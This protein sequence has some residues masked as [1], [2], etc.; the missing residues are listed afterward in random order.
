MITILRKSGVTYELLE[1]PGRDRIVGS[2]LIV[3]DSAAG[4]KLLLQ[5]IDVNY[6]SVPGEIEE[7]IR[8]SKREESYQVFEEDEHLRKILDELMDSRILT[9]KVRAAFSMDDDVIDFQ[10][11]PSRLKSRIYEPTIDELSLLIRKKYSIP[12]KIGEELQIDLG[13]F[14]GGLT[15]II[16]KKGSGKSNLSKMLVTRIAE[17]GGRCLVFDVNGEYEPIS[18]TRSFLVLKPGVNMLLSISSLGK[19]LFLVLMETLMGLPPSSTWEL[20]RILDSLEARNALTLRNLWNEVVTGRFNDLVKEAIVR[21]LTVLLESGLFKDTGSTDFE[22]LFS[23][24]SKKIIVIKLKGLPR[25][26]RQLIVETV[27]NKIVK[28][29]ESGL[30]QPLFL[31]AEEAQTYLDEKAWEDYITRMRHIGFSVM[32]ITNEPDSLMGFVYRQA[33]NCFIFNLTNEND[34]NYISK[35]SKM[36]AESLMRLV[37]TLPVGRCIAFGNV[38]GNIPVLLSLQKESVFGTGGTRRVLLEA[39]PRA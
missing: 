26:F 20:R 24:S 34:L 17:H 2:Y 8:I 10:W 36:D 28:M 14:D 4:R 21:R 16:G 15:L 5:I 33:D 31:F 7:I 38:T 27:L 13:A 11:T 3:L 32:F 35:M 23:D 30:I 25:V 1:T 18:Q 22:R 39:T 19:E 29:L 6:L 37:P 12:V 9:C